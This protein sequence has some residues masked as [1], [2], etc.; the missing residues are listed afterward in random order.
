MV[1][2]IEGRDNDE[3]PEPPRLRALRRLVTLLTITLIVGV[4]TVVAML[5]LRLTALAPASVPRLPSEVILPMGETARAVTFGT[6]WI[7][8]VTVDSA[9]AER[10]RVLEA[11]TGADRGTLEIVPSR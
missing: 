8:V 11:K 9:G 2:S 7:A 10:I 4:T 5:A 3:D 6:G 1:G